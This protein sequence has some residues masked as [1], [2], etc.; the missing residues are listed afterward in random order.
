MINNYFISGELEMSA[1]SSSIEEDIFE[2][3]VRWYYKSGKLKET[4]N[5]KNGLMEGYVC[6]YDSTG[7]LLAKCLYKDNKAYHGIYYTQKKDI[8]VFSHIKNGISTLDEITDIN[9]Q[10]KAK[11][12]VELLNDHYQ[13]KIFNIKGEYIGKGEFDQDGHKKNGIFADIMFRPMQIFSLEYVT[14]GKVDSTC[15]FYRNGL[16]KQITKGEGD[17]KTDTYFDQSGKQ[18]GTLHYKGKYPYEG[19]KLEFPVNMHVYCDHVSRYMKYKNGYLHGQYIEY[20]T[21]GLPREVGQYTEGDKDGLFKYYDE[22]GN[23]YCEGWFKKGKKMNGEFGSYTNYLDKKIYK[24]G[25]FIEGYTHHKNGVLKEHVIIDSLRLY[26]DK[27]GNEIARSS[28]KNNRVYN[29]TSARFRNNGN[30]DS[31]NFYRNGRLFKTLKYRKYDGS[32]KLEYYYEDGRKTKGIAYYSSGEIFAKIESPNSNLEKWTYFSKEGHVIAIFEKRDHVKNGDLYD[33][34]NDIIDN[35]TR[36]RN[37]TVVYKKQFTS[38]GN[39]LYEAD[40]N[41]SVKYYNKWG[42]VI[43]QGSY[44]DGQPYD[45]TFYTYDHDL[46]VKKIFHM[47]NGVKKNL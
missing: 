46:H 23:L 25:T 20:H 42:K 32:L 6:Q 2:G 21:N 18:M 27:Q 14:E 43:A 5:Y 37:D 10:G 7:Q 38:G 34:D 31:K 28:D 17:N 35:I 39:V 26:Y 13:Q 4:A 15:Y 47:K 16:I 30:I 3:E 19:L 9:A 11:I 45:G 22:Q 33:F 12:M 41:G 44:R 1:Q 24:D 36:Y 40:F 8:S 29:G